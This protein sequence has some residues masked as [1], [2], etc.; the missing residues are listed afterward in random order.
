MYVDIF[1]G[2]NCT[3]YLEK[4]KHDHQVEWPIPEM[5]V[6]LSDTENTLLYFFSMLQIQCKMSRDATSVSNPSTSL[7]YAW[8]HV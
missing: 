1:V 5:E 2:D 8:L 3:V 6:E 4:G 7:I